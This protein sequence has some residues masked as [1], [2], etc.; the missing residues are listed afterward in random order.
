VRR[1]FLGA[2]S[3]CA[4]S[5]AASAPSSAQYQFQVPSQRCFG[6]AARDRL[7]PCVNPKLAFAVVPSPSDALITP[8]PGC[9]RAQYVGL[10]NVCLFGDPAAGGTNQ[11]ALVGDSHAWHWKPAVEVLA[12]GERA[13]GVSITRT[14]CPFSASTVS[15]SGPSAGQCAQWNQLLLRWFAAHPAV[16]TVFVSA[17]STSPARTVGQRAALAKMI[18]GNIAAWRALPATVKHIIVIRDTPLNRFDTLTCV[19]RA[20]A[21]HQHAGVVCALP[22]RTALT[23]RTDAPYLAALRLHSSRVRIVDLT[24]FFCDSR[25]CYPVVGGALVYRDIGHLTDAFSASLGPFLLRAVER[26][27]PSPAP[28]PYAL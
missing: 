11:I 7:A 4:V 8:S 21:R 24:P 28:K 3:V 16:G 14:S 22:R 15:I 23:Q 2:L 27:L 12:R 5:V 10:L 26:L 18:A 1:A 9:P 20:E 6:A 19:E 25:L 13:S 17:H